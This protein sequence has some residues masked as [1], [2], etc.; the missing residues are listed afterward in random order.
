MAQNVLTCT[1]PLPD[2]TLII[3]LLFAANRI[4]TGSGFLHPSQMDRSQNC[5]QITPGKLSHTDFDILLT[6]HLNIFNLIL[7]NLMH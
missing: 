4:L 7:N 5:Y 6:V 3:S 1:F 2:T